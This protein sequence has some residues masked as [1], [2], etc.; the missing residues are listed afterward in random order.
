MF[1]L[2]WKG[3]RG[4]DPDCKRRALNRRNK[5]ELPKY[6]TH[7]IPRIFPERYRLVDIRTVRQSHAMAPG[8]HR[9]PDD[10][11][12]A[13]K[14]D[15][16]SRPRFPPERR[17]RRGVSLLRHV[18]RCVLDH[19]S[20]WATSVALGCQGACSA[21]LCLTKHAHPSPGFSRALLW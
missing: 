5:S 3:G 1:C 12:G 10:E 9:V 7:P 17:S 4:G 16:G 18:G 21:L 15:T 2:L 14:H 6:E 8:I 19:T 20:G 13:R 11:P